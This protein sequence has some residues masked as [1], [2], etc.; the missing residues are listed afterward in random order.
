MTILGLQFWI[1]MKPYSNQLYGPTALPY[2]IGVTEKNIFIDQKTLIH[3]LRPGYHTT[4]HIIPKILETT[5][6]FNT[7]DLDVRKCKLPH[8][9]T[10][11]RFFQEYSRKGC[12]IECAARK[13]T[14]F[15]K[16]LPWHYPNNFSSLPMCDIFGG[17]CFDEIM[18]NIVYYKKCKTECLEDCQETS[19]FMWH[20]SVP[21]NTE[22]LCKGSTYFDKFFLQ[23]YERLFA[24]ENY[25]ML[26]QKH[27][28]LDLESSLRNG[29]LCKAY[30]SKYVSLVSIES[31]TKSITKAQRDQRK[32]FFDKLST[33]GGTLAV[34]AG[35]SVISMF[36]VVVF[37]YIVFMGIVLDVRDLWNKAFTYLRKTGS[38]TKKKTAPSNN[39]AKVCYDNINEGQHEIKKLYVST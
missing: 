17:Y 22:T 13:A 5:S 4:L 1:N 38:A 7:L 15:C 26:V 19:L 31:P 8:E 28:T 9:T 3:K 29:S 14:S 30:I 39:V 6:A 33:V 24:F 32:F 34:S 12:E 11:F 25:Q 21:L 20:N 27:S 2:T 36:E 18:S 16:C 10:G 35:F 23:N 37:V